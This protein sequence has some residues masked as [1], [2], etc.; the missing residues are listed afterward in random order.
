MDLVSAVD[1]LIA[2]MWQL[3]FEIMHG[4][5]EGA[6]LDGHREIDRI[7]VGLAMEAAGQVG[8]RIDRRVGFTAVG[9]D[10]GRL[11]TPSFLW[12]VQEGEEPGE[13]DLIA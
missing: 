8:A 12:P 4:I 9:T 6:V 3:G 11:V 10:K 13:R 5:H 2:V 7:E 1:R